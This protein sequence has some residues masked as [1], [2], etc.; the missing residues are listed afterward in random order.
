MHKRKCCFWAFKYPR[1]HLRISSVEEEVSALTKV[2]NGKVLRMKSIPLSKSAE[3]AQSHRE[4]SALLPPLILTST[5]LQDRKQMFS[6]EN[7]KDVCGQATLREF[8][9]DPD[10]TSFSGTCSCVTLDEYL[11][12]TQTLKSLSS[13][14][15]SQLTARPA[16][17]SALDAVN[18]N[19]NSNNN[20]NSSTSSTTTSEMSVDANSN[21]TSTPDQTDELANKTLY[22]KNVICLSSWRAV[23]NECFSNTPFSFNSPHNLFNSLP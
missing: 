21:A 8:F 20:N 4:G 14:S 15:P 18:S 9:M 19:A 16:T 17:S 23:I 2:P 10:E 22:A 5:G 6:F 11:D 12:Y 3:Y 7:L 13:P 1:K